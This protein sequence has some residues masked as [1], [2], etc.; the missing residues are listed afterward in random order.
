MDDG[1]REKMEGLERER[2][3]GRMG[4]LQVKEGGTVGQKN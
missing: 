1:K 2:E 3:E 4:C